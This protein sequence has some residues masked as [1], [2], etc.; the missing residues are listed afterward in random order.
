[1]AHRTWFWNFMARRYFKQAIVDPGAYQT[2]LEMTAAH[3]RK[4]MRLFEFGCGT[5]GTALIHAPK[6]QEVD[7]IDVSP[8][9][10]EIAVQQ[11][12][13]Q[14]VSNV[15][16]HVSAIQDWAFPAQAYDMILGLSILHLLT[17]R[18]LVIRQVYENLADDG[19]FVTSTACIGDMPGWPKYALPVATRLGLVPVL[20]V[21]T[22][23]QLIED[24]E[25]AG[26]EVIEQFRPKPDAALF[27]ICRKKR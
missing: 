12:E 10:I 25:T 19:L 6:V 21:F 27:L 15:N 22:A 8:R 26:F 14:Q 5:G 2:K 4:D 9:M 7:A 18:Q 1:M 17:D 11:A 3:L 23:E 20:R 24:M 13:E 16:F